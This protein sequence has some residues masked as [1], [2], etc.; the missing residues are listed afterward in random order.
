MRQLLRD[1]GRDTRLMML[2]YLLWGIAEGLWMFLLPLYLKY[3]GATPDQSGL[4]IGLWGAGRLFVILP[5]GWL[6]DRV[7][8]RRIL[9]P[10]WYAGLLG[11]V[12]LALAPDWRW[13]V[14]A[15]LMYGVSAAVIPVANLY[16]VQAGQHDPTRL[17]SVPVS[18]SLTL[19][20]A[21]YTA[22]VVLTPSLG[23][24]LGDQLGLRAVYWISTAWLVLS[25][26]AVT[27]THHYPVP[28]LPAHGYAPQRM[29]RRP[30]VLA[31]L[32]IITLGFTALLTGQPLSSQYLE[33]VRRFSRTAIGVFGSLSA[34][35]TTFFSVAL[36]RLRPWTGFYFSL[37]L[38]G[39]S[40]V[41]FANSGALWVVVLAVFLLGAHY[42][43]RPLASAI[44]EPMVE[45][46]Q[47]GMAF[48]VVEM[49]V[50]FAA[51]G[52]PAAA[53]FLYAYDP[54]SPF[55]AGAVGVVLVLA[56]SALWQSGKRRARRNTASVGAYKKMGRALD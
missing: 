44:I 33:E 7:G 48:A 30:G 55:V 52:G 56:L 43:A 46:H 36:G 37:A 9:L 27:A 45:A 47:R 51:T 19:L 28:E 8:A 23:G 2:S 22:G 50:G 12:G 54:R 21:S 35:G 6:A 20:W 25:T 4:V 53:G 32:G 10:G 17:P 49:L 14:P 13:T 29:L 38:A 3:L 31:A 11:V 39:F 41:L 40:F 18:T 1:L 34:L 42:A 15:M 5:A 16:L 26:L 24:W